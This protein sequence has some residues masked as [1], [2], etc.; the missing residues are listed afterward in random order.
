MYKTTRGRRNYLGCWKKISGYCFGQDKEADKPS[1]REKFE[2]Q[3]VPKRN[4]GKDDKSV[5][6]Q[7]LCSPQRH[8]NISLRTKGISM[9]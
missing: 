6:E 4:K 8:V 7:M 1:P 5:S 9:Q 3:I 2:C